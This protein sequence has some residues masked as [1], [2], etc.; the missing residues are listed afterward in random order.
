MVSYQFFAASKRKPEDQL[1]GEIIEAILCRGT[2]NIPEIEN[3]WKIKFW[4]KFA[5]SEKTFE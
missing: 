5:L 2:V 1:R 4:D 3:R